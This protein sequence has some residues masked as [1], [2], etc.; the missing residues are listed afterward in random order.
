MLKQFT[1]IALMAAMSIVGANAQAISQDEAMNN[2]IRFLT[3][4]PENGGAR[5]VM[6]ARPRL[7][8]AKM[9]V[10]GV[11]AF[12]VEG[13][14]FVIASGDSRT[15]PVLGYG[16]GGSFDWDNMPQNMREWL[17]GYGKTIAALGNTPVSANARKADSKRQAI[18]PMIQTYWNQSPVYNLECPVYDGVNTKYKGQ[19]TLTGCVATAMAQIMYYYK[20]PQDATTEIP[21][22]DYELTLAIPSQ[23]EFDSEP[24][25]Y[26]M[27]KIHLDKLPSTTFDWGNMLPHYTKLDKQ[28]GLFV[29]LETTKQQQDAVAHLMR[30]CGQAI[31]M[32]YSPVVSN[33]FTD[34]AV[35]ALRH[36]FGYD[37]GIHQANRSNYTIDG[38]EDL[39]Y[40][41][42]SAGRPVFYAANSS[43]GGHGF[44]C[45]GYDGEGLYHINWGW[46]GEY[47]NYFALSV[48]NPYETNDIE[49]ASDAMGFSLEQEAIIGMQPPTGNTKPA[50]EDPKLVA[51]SYLSVNDNK[52]GVELSY[53]S[54]LYPKANFK[55]GLFYPTE[56]GTYETA[57]V[58]PEILSLE[59][60]A[61]TCITIPIEQ[62]DHLPK[63]GCHLFLLYQW[64][65]K[66]N[67]EWQV[68]GSPY[69]YINVSPNDNGYVYM[70]SI[71]NILYIQKSYFIGSGKAMDKHDIVLEIQD[72]GV[73]YSGTVFLVPVYTNGVDPEKIFKTLSTLDEIV[74]GAIPDLEAKLRA[75]VYLKPG[76]SQKVTFSYTPETSGLIMFV[77]YEENNRV[78]L[79]YITLLFDKQEFDIPYP[80]MLSDYEISYQKANSA[81]DKFIQGKA[82]IDALVDWISNKDNGENYLKIGVTAAGKDIVAPRTIYQSLNCFESYEVSIDFF[83]KDKLV[84]DYPQ[85]VTIY[86]DAIKKNNNI[87]LF[88]QKLKLGETKKGNNVIGEDAGIPDAIEKVNVDGNVKRYYDLSGRPL[89][90]EPTTSGVYIYKD[91]SSKMRKVFKK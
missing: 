83:L 16:N 17:K 46:E 34:D 40:G 62:I 55:L 77:L 72:L 85:T 13:G 86:V 65:D 37:E 22:Y 7:H 69:M 56:N 47:D 89:N 32:Y 91:S 82:K 73:E 42:L 15:L 41:E 78:P 44:I 6:K 30:Y 10:K 8:A 76:E 49:K 75:G 64:A 80:L 53:Y 1:F 90:G 27:D 70:S 71:N 57:Y 9:D 63:D 51:Q 26:T 39:I 43:D 45:D 50:S 52:I 19:S 21:A 2:A 29:P 67:S 88:E 3:S 35:Y 60:N 25:Q 74:P 38:W 61:D 24:V 14:G 36:Y 20:W 79:G 11:Y 31:K 66:E 4:T 58:V 48:L 59:C 28:S 54:A 5:K 87:R 33:A 12:N 23:G 84:N 68:V 81:D 18:N